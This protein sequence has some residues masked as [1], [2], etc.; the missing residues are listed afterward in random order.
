MAIQQRRKF[1]DTF[2]H[3]DTI[4]ACDEQTDGRTDA[5]ENSHNECCFLAKSLASC[6]CANDRISFAKPTCKDY[7]TEHFSL[8]SRAKFGC[9]AAYARR[10]TEIGRASCRERV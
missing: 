3:F 5:R 2:I 7:R 8:H 9:I 6:S 1:D 4:P 10:P